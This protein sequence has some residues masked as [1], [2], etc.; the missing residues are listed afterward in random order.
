MSTGE[1]EH[2]HRPRVAEHRV[3]AR[4]RAGVVAIA[5]RRRLE[6]VGARRPASPRS[7]SG[8][9]AGDGRPPRGRRL[10]LRG[11]GARR[12][13]LAV[14]TPERHVEVAQVVGA[15][16][17]IRG[18]T[19]NGRARRRAPPTPRPRTRRQAAVGA[20]QAWVAGGRRV[21][22]ES[23]APRRSR[24]AA[25]VTAAGRARPG[26]VAPPSSAAP[27]SAAPWWVAPWSVRPWCGATV[28][29]AAVR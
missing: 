2:V 8:P 1:P 12:C 26:E 17:G 24:R 21:R 11:R 9:R 29:G 3:A 22:P 19:S 28:E 27:S 25:A 20:T 13:G 4:E 7:G 10:R 23:A 14:E 5:R 18:A 6:L 16:R 15:R